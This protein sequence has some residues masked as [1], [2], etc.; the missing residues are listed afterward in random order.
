M[1]FICLLASLYFRVCFIGDFLITDCELFRELLYMQK[2]SE[3]HG[4][5][6]LIKLSLF[7]V[8]SL[9]KIHQEV[10]SL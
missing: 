7:D 2:A 9:G 1:L 4:G 10:S 8:R 6:S 5:K 3:E